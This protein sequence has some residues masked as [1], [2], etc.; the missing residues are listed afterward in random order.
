MIIEVVAEV[1]DT[2][3]EGKVIL[4]VRNL[5]DLPLRIIERKDGRFIVGSC[6]SHTCLTKL[7]ELIRNQEIEDTTHMIL[8]RSINESGIEFRVNKQAAY[9]GVLSFVTEGSESPLGPIII[10]IRGDDIRGIIDWLCFRSTR[11][12][13]DP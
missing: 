4:A 3:D 8:T 9:V 7:R 12:P 5:V 11:P 6:N 2:E 10:R 13:G 1:R